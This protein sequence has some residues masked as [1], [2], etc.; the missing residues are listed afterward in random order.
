MRRLGIGLTAMSLA[1]FAL[2]VTAQAQ[3]TTGGIVGEVVISDS[4]EPYLAMVEVYDATESLVTSK[5]TFPDGTFNVSGLE[6]GTYKV[7]VA[8]R[9]FSSA[10]AFADADPVI[11]NAGEETAGIKINFSASE[12]GWIEGRVYDALTGDPVEVIILGTIPP[13]P[14]GT[15][16]LGLTPG[17]WTVDFNDVIGFKY[18]PQ[19][20]DYRPDAAS[21]DILNV[22]AGVTI[23]G[24]D[25]AMELPQDDGGWIS[26]VVTGSDT[27]DPV[28]GIC[29]LPYN[30]DGEL[31][32]LPVNASWPRT[33]LDGVFRVG[34]LGTGEY[35]LG[36][37]DCADFVW[38]EK[39]WEDGTDFATA[40]PIQVTIGD[41]VSGINIV[42]DLQPGVVRPAPPTTTTT[43]GSEQSELPY[44]GQENGSLVLVL[45]A[46]TLLVAGLATLALDRGH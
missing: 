19:W 9:W 20:W 10:T 24:V 22:V 29:V 33:E 7:K 36:F 23:T 11:V 5:E 17:A 34:F 38:E 44:T 3:E 40:T 39:W 30:T 13:D 42:L 14:D 46:S 41:E 43:T 28:R 37:F 6:P 12:F 18:A 35:R 4:T 45:A 8:N 15:Y 21:A 26:G 27:G 2:A 31:P 32:S 25:A 1:F 16:R